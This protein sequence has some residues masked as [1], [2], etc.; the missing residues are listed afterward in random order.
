MADVLVEVRLL[1]KVFGKEGDKVTALDNIS[2]DVY[3][4]EFMVIVG[5]SGC[6]K[7]TLLRILAGLIQ[8]SSGDLRF[9]HSSSDIKKGGISMVFQSPNL[10]PWRKVLANVLLPL[11]L[12]GINASKYKDKALDLL[13]LAGLHGF[14]SR[15]TFELSGGMQQRVSLVRSLI[16]DPSI[17]LMDEPFGALDAIT[18]ERMNL[19]LLRIWSEAKKTV[20]FVTHSITEAAFLAD[21]IVVMTPRPGKIREILTND[22]PRPRTLDTLKLPRFSELAAKIRELIGLGAGTEAS[23]SGG[24]GE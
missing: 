19:E 8:P 5:S 1:S 10:L 16:T 21:R 24:F 20:V 18:R 17:L 23:A 22:L 14:E 11:E 2:M 3:S 6:G 9:N 12:R 4:G 15:Y 7:T 13:K